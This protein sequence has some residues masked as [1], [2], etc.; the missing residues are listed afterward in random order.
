[1][2]DDKLSAL[3]S[4]PASA[5]DQASIV[6]L[7]EGYEGQLNYRNA[8]HRAHQSN[9]LRLEDTLNHVLDIAFS[10]APDALIE[11]AFLHPMG[12]ADPG[13]FESLSDDV[14]ARRT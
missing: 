5:S 8:K 9:L 2:G 3:K 1:M 7:P 13:P 14:N 12:V 11:D 6:G 4:L 10:I